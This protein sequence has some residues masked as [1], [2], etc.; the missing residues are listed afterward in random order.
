[1]GSNL[2]SSMSRRGDC[3]DNVPQESFFGQMK[4]D[5]MQRIVDATEFLKIK[6]AIDDYIDSYNYMQG[7]CEK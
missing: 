3:W 6:E 1:M 5:V 2:S 4:D 7:S